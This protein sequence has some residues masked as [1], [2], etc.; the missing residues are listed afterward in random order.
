MPFLLSPE[1]SYPIPGFPAPE[2]LPS[3]EFPTDFLPILVQIR[4]LQI[5]IREKGQILPI[6]YRVLPVVGCSLLPTLVS[7]CVPERRQT[8]CYSVSR[9]AP[10]V[11]RGCRAAAF[12]TVRE[13]SFSV[14]PATNK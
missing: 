6:S 11:P 4:K 5:Q 7:V 2:F 12:G 8:E 3:W 1:I 9:V 14:S 13:F 10:R